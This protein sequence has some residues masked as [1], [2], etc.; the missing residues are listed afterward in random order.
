MAKNITLMGAD[1][2]DVPA[3]VLPQTSGGSATFTDTSD[4]TATESDVLAGKYFH[5]AN[6]ER[7]QGS[8]SV[9][10]VIDNLNSTSA[11]DALSANQGKVL[12]EKIGLKVVKGNF[13]ITTG[14]F[15]ERTINSNRDIIAVQCDN[16]NIVGIPY[17][18]GKVKFLNMTDMRAENNE[19]ITGYYWYVE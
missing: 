7:V 12:N 6:G 13:D 16:S 10:N 2:P 8:L 17:N 19:N 9:P 4:T 5:K 14:N 11:T 3:V 15:G 1:Y 18:K